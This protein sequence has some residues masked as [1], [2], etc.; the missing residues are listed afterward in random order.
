[1]RFIF[2]NFFMTWKTYLD[3]SFSSRKSIYSFLQHRQDYA[4]WEESCILCFQPGVRYV[5]FHSLSPF[6]VQ[7]PSILS[8]L[9]KPVLT[10]LSDDFMPQS[11]IEMLPFSRI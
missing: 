11:E 1:M 9:I 8:S 6:V 3:F 2:S 4:N 10:K 7:C 5:I